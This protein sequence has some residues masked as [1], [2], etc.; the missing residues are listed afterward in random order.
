MEITL[1]K[2]IVLGFAACAV[3]LL[4]V[5]IFSFKTSEKF[6]ASNV[7]VNNSNQ[8][9]YEFEQILMTSVDAETGVHGYV[10]TGDENFLQP[11]ASA[12]TK[13]TDL[14]AKV[15][16]LTKDNPNQQ[17]NIEELAKELKMRFDNLS[18]CIILRKN[19]FEKAR[20]FVDSSEGKKI[21]DAIRKTIEKAQQTERTLLTERIQTS[22][23][24]ARNF[25]LVFIILLLLIIAILVIVYTIVAT[26][27]KVLKKSESETAAKNW[28]LY[29]Q[30]KT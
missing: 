7:L 14:L 2:K 12:K 24:D 3:V 21:Q 9:L 19:N 23:N 20:E 17:K 4:I 5:A 6:V 28:L 18:K 8:V 25:N 11:F 29:R 10:I 27:L 13:S 15:K 22:K 1:V 16:E 26:N 30:F